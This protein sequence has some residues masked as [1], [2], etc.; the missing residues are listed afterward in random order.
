[1]RRSGISMA[2]NERVSLA[3]KHEVS[4]T[5]LVKQLLSRLSPSVKQRA[6][7]DASYVNQAVA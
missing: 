1:M 5:T 4:K 6:K 7:L 3:A 2:Q